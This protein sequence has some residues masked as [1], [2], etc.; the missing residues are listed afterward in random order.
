M[1]AIAPP[2]IAKSFSPD[3]ITAGNTSTLQFT[4]TNSNTGTALTGVAFTDTLPAG[5]TVPSAATS[6]CGGTLTV[7]APDSITLSGGT[8]AASGNCIF[9]VTVTGATTGTKVNTSGALSSTN[10]GT[11]NTATDTLTV[12]AATV[13]DPAV[14]KAV[15]PS[16]AQVGDTVTFTLVITNGGTGNADDVVVTDVIP[17]FLDISTVIVSPPG[18]GIAISGNTI[19]LTFG[20]VAPRRYFHCDDYDRGEQ[21]GSAAGRDQ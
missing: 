17:A 11:G 12:G 5:V 16:A 9:S 4:I 8:V 6:E 15:S 7:A 13:S 3:S 1:T 18:P 21:L 20:T 10:G 2:S 19:T 14:T